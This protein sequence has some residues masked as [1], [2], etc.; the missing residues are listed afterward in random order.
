[1]NNHGERVTAVFEAAVLLEPAERLSFV[2]EACADD[3]ALQRQVESMLADVDQP[4]MIDRPVDEAI[5]DLMAMIRRSWL[6]RSSARIAWSRC[7]AR[8]AWGRSIGPLT[9]SSAA[10]WRS[11]SCRPTSRRILNGLRGSAARRKR[12]PPSTI[13]TSAPSTGSRT[14]DGRTGSAFGLVLE[15]VE[16]ATLAEKLTAGPLPVEEALAIAQQ[17]AEALDAAHQRGIVHRDLKP[18]N[19]KVRDDGTVKVL[20]FGLATVAPSENAR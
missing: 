15:L 14:L 20:D 3:P 12:S 1:M 17:I 10:R 9:R 6:G 11:R 8:A 2:R 4:V 19:I 5:A 7:S 16:G 13:P 18:G